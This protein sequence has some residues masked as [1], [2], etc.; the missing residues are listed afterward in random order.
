MQH[1]TLE[2]KTSLRGLQLELVEYVRG[3]AGVDELQP[4]TNPHIIGINYTP[5]LPYLCT[6]TY[7]FST[8]NR[9]FP[10]ECTGTKNMH[11]AQTFP[12]ES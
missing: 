5:F 2:S 12:G 6:I 7:K 11:T 4:T 8:E 10:R 1:K 9:F 3:N